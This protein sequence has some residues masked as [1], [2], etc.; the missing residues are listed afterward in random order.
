MGGEVNDTKEKCQQAAEADD[1]CQSNGYV[2]IVGFGSLLSIKSARFTFPKLQEFALGRVFGYRRLFGH[3]AALFLDNGMADL[4]KR[5]FASLAA[6]PIEECSDGP[7]NTGMIVS[8][9]SI[10][11]EDMPKFY[12][13][14]EEF[15]FDQVKVTELNSGDVRVGLICRAWNDEA[16][17]AKWG[18]ER[19]VTEYES[20]G[21][22]SIWNYK[23][24][25]YPC[26]AYCRHCIL[27]ARSHGENVE[28][29]F[30]AT[31]FL[32]D[33]KTSRKS[34]LCQCPG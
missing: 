25:L 28:A 18:R 15:Q 26:P 3:P 2:S 31:T 11:K 20:R 21:I 22:S 34:D 29:D 16:L 14:E 10:K 8:V 33:R 6:W 30:L 12:A 32:Y 1:I 19:F 4:E 17:V 27:S 9:F 23:G 24:E 5:N 13:R 7:D